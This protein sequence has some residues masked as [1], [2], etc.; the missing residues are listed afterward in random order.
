MLRVLLALLCLV[1]ASA[2]AAE[3]G[4]ASF[5]ADRFD[6]RR[7]ASGETFRQSAATCAHKTLPLGARIR[8]ERADGRYVDCR[9]NDR[10]PFVRGRVVDLSRSLANR[11]GMAKAGVISVCLRRI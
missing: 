7:T 3:C 11:L 6:G 1:V 5:Y 8:V 9:V 10:G 4:K 2:A